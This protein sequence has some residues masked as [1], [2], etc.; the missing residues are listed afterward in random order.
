MGQPKTQDV[1]LGSSCTGQSKLLGLPTSIKGW[2]QFSYTY[3][4][5]ASSLTPK[6]RGGAISSEWGVGGGSSPMKGR[7][8]SPAAMSSEKQGQLSQGQWRVG[9]AQHSP[10]SS[11]RM[12]PMAPCVN[13]AMDINTDPSCRG[14]MDPNMALSSSPAGHRDPR[15]QHRP[16]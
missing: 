3:A 9:P 7:T 6:V 15:W 11:T 4:I 5:G 1:G 14:T 13:R 8:S 12:V 10:Q 16:L 2:S